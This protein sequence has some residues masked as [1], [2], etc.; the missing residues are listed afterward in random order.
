M[1]QETDNAKIL[2]E[3][4]P[5]SEDWQHLF[6]NNGQARFSA[7]PRRSSI[8][9]LN[10]HSLA[11]AD[12]RSST[13][14]VSWAQTFQYK[15]VLLDGT[16]VLTSQELNK[17]GPINPNAIVI[18]ATNE[19]KNDDKNENNSNNNSPKMINCNDENIQKIKNKFEPKHLPQV[20]SKYYNPKNDRKD[21][22][23]VINTA[24]NKYGVEIDTANP[25]NNAAKLYEIFKRDYPSQEQNFETFLKHFNLDDEPQ[26]QRLSS[27]PVKA[28]DSIENDINQTPSINS[29]AE[30]NFLN[31]TKI[32]ESHH[33][34]RSFSIIDQSPI[35]NDGDLKN[36]ELDSDD[37]DNQHSI[38]KTIHNTSFM[39]LE[40]NTDEMPDLKKFKSIEQPEI[41]RL[42]AHDMSVD[43]SLELSPTKKSVDP[44]SIETVETLT[45]DTNMAISENFE[46]DK[47]EIENE[48]EIFVDQ[49]CI[50]AKMPGKESPKADAMN[51]LKKLDGTPNTDYSISFEEDDDDDNDLNLKNANNDKPEKEKVDSTES[52]FVDQSCIA[53]KM[54]GKESPKADAMNFL[55]KLDGTPNTDYSISFED[56]D[57]DNDLNLKNANNDKPEK[58]KVDSTESIF[59]DQSCIAAKMPGKESPK[60]DAMNFLKKLDDT[61]NTDYSINSKEDSDD[62]NGLNL[63]NENNDKPEKEKVDPTESISKEIIEQQPQLIHASTFDQINIYSS[64][65]ES[66]SITKNTK[67]DDQ[68]VSETLGK[69][70]FEKSLQLHDDHS[71]DLISLSSSSGSSLSIKNKQKT[72]ENEHFMTD[73]A[74]NLENSTINDDRKLAACLT[75]SAT[76][77]TTD[78]IVG[79]SKIDD[80]KNLTSFT[81]ATDTSNHNVNDN[82]QSKSDGSTLF[83]NDTSQSLFH[84][85]EL[86]TPNTSITESSDNFVSSNNKTLMDSTLIDKKTLSMEKSKILDAK[87]RDIIVP[88]NMMSKDDDD[89]AYTEE[90]LLKKIEPLIEGNQNDHYQSI[91]IADIDYSKTDLTLNADDGDDDD[92]QV[93]IIDITNDKTN[94]LSENQTPYVPTKPIN[95]G[96]SM[97]EIL[98]YQ[99]MSQEQQQQ[100]N[101][102]ETNNN[103]NDDEQN[104]LIETNE[105]SV[106]N[107]VPDPQEKE[108][109]SLSINFK[110]PNLDLMR[111]SM[112]MSMSVN[113]SAIIKQSQQPPKQMTGSTVAEII[114]EMSQLKSTL[115]PPPSTSNS[116]MFD[117]NRRSMINNPERYSSKFS[118][119]KSN[120]NTNIIR[121]S[122]SSAAQT[123]SEQTQNLN[124]SL[125]S[126]YEKSILGRKSLGITIREKLLERV[127]QQR[128]EK[129]KEAEILESN[130]TKESKSVEN[131]ETKQSQQIIENEESKIDDNVVDDSE[132]QLDL[133]VTIESL[134]QDPDEANERVLSPIEMEQSIITMLDVVD[135]SHDSIEST[136]TNKE[137]ANII[138]DN[139]M[140]NN[141]EQEKDYNLSL[142]ETTGDF[143][144]M[145]HDISRMVNDED[146]MA[147]NLEYS[148]F[149]Q[150]EE[151]IKLLR[152]KQ[153]PIQIPMFDFINDLDHRKLNVRI[154]SVSQNL[155]VLRYLFSTLELRI[156]FGSIVTSKIF[157][158]SNTNKN[159]D[160]N[161]RH[162][163]REIVAID[164]ISLIDSN[165]PLQNDVI[166]GR[167]DRPIYNGDFFL[168][169][170][171][172]DEHR[173]L[174]NLAQ[175]YVLTHFEEKRSMFDKKFKDTSKLKELMEEFSILVTPAKK[176]ACELR[177]LLSSEISLLLPNDSDGKIGISV[178]IL[179]IRMNT[180]VIFHFYFDHLKYPDEVIH[181]IIIVPDKDRHLYPLEEFIVALKMIKPCEYNYIT[182]LIRG[183]RCFIRALKHV[184]IR[185]RSSQQQSK[186]IRATTQ[187]EIPRSA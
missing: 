35:R 123:L 44:M 146:E 184:M 171:E 31:S 125:S 183:T 156:H 90:I 33:S 96:K 9:K 103:M 155:L 74:M 52:I 144:M 185:N 150:F 97:T 47:P 182:R 131:D 160:N 149:N 151:T 40:S 69:K 3:I 147:E 84:E 113:Q 56:D 28:S 6:K 76:I 30:K 176:M 167:K 82:E 66:C 24:L 89:S 139:E 91:F 127:N 106:E 120:F 148:I 2:D 55:K 11:F 94:D 178:Q 180:A 46:S 85:F 168:L 58:E 153:R 138:E 173:R 62:D 36:I 67:T 25:I 83:K 124:D 135:L 70:D 27:Q 98:E 1:S 22:A 111:P 100:Q 51:F 53:A 87:P 95:L 114:T 79:D 4:D 108:I 61:P 23:T 80:L 137:A 18:P 109:D 92:V 170:F 34:L 13:R 101:D 5:N 93:N 164:V 118:Q 142:S 119:S 15:E 140:E 122:T 165:R 14:R 20:L 42:Q 163:I 77:A 88:D 152:R 75:L 60:A 29:P 115:P 121:L 174:L 157:R 129:E 172:T 12:R 136:E 41:D 26:Q 17:Y 179:G 177:K 161:H 169:S 73:V 10:E 181:P 133:N 86:V 50:A 37:D 16:S 99:N 107:I 128:Q 43:M 105:A 166:R 54:P 21:Y 130:E 132:L 141:D 162:E 158:H 145:M 126:F 143:S 39:Q 104:N 63:K 19:Q 175:D 7:H 59:V 38:A 78:I 48:F 81:L 154:Q 186:Q 64:S 159:D 68:K 65:I 187:F 102:E 8:L 45:S 117:N 49:S 57:D 72:A 110:L 134:Q 32:S 112:K 71:K 116:R